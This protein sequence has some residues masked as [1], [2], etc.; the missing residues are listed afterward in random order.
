M[1]QKCPKLC[2]SCSIPLWTWDFF[3]ISPMASS[4]GKWYNVPYLCNISYP[5]YIFCLGFPANICKV[6][7]FRYVHV[8]YAYDILTCISKGIPIWILL[9]QNASRSSPLQ[10]YSSGSHS[11]S[12]SES[13]CLANNFGSPLILLSYSYCLQTVVYGRVNSVLFKIFNYPKPQNVT[14]TLPL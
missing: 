7:S 9:T 2:Y 6:I 1:V 13:T 8:S 10:T 4:W 14:F 3:M 5:G 12:V 11:L